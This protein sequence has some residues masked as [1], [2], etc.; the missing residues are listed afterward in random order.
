MKKIAIIAFMLFS[1]TASA[2]QT[3]LTEGRRP[4]AFAGAS[5]DPMNNSS[6]SLEAGVWGMEKA[7]SYSITFDHMRG[8]GMQSNWIGIKPY[9]TIFDN[10]KISYMLYASP[11]FN[12]AN[13]NE[14]IIEFGFNPNYVVSKNILFGVTMGNQVTSTSQWNM[15]FGAGFVFLK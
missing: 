13:F 5:S 14:K 11:K 7:T 12:L 10:G 3:K 1:I 2:Q 9:F 15:F 6:L 4:F 8:S